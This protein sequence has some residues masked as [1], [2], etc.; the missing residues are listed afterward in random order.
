MLLH[1]L[2]WTTLTHYSHASQTKKLQLF[3]NASARLLSRSSNRAH[4]S[5]FLASLHWLLVKYRIDLTILSFTYKVL[6][7]QAPACICELLTPYSTNRS[8]RSSVQG[9]LAIPWTTFRTERSLL[10]PP[11]FGTAS[12]WTSSQ[13]AAL[14]VLKPTCTDR[15]FVDVVFFCFDV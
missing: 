11:C 9:H 14:T 12:P 3:Q 15:P 8:L 13:L 7:N 6:N 1:H 2:T 5:S 10:W 4:I